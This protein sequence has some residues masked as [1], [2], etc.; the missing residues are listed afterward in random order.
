LSGFLTTY[1]PISLMN[2]PRIHTDLLWDLGILFGGIT[3]LYFLLV[4]LFRYRIAGR[5]RQVHLRKRELA[6][7]ITKFLFFRQDIDLNE[8]EAY[9]RMKIEIR[10]QLKNPL[11]REVLTEVLMDLRQD[12]TGEAR[13]RLLS[14]YQD[15]GLHLDAF[16]KLKSVRWEKVSMGILE[17]TEMRVDQAYHIVKKRI[18]DKRSVIRKQAQLAVVNLREEGI[19]YVLDT[20]R[21]PIS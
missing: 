18:N 8:R 5:R 14:L 3:A 6:P 7:M 9:I 16:Q 11:N 17:L 10:D 2:P 4:L 20:A 12:V 21:H 15:L 13:T 19:R 1:Q